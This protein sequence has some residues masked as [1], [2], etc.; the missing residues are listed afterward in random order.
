MSTSILDLDWCMAQEVT[1]S[2]EFWKFMAMCAFTVNLK[3]IF[4]HLDATLPKYQVRMFGWGSTLL[5]LASLCAR[6]R[7][8]TKI[9]SPHQFWAQVRRARGPRLQHQPRH[10]RGPGSDRR[11]AHDH[12]QP[13]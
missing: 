10:D 9:D 1:R 6:L 8:R 5:M 3:S 11:R 12:V 13:L 2:R 7:K 4:R